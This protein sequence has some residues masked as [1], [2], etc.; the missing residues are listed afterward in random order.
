MIVIPFDP[1]LHLGPFALSWHGIFTAVGI[2]FGVALPVRLLRGRV[3]EDAA[4]SVATWG[5]IG[6]IVGARAVHVIDR[7]DF[8]AA[9]PIQILM[10]WNGGIAVLGAVLGGVLAGAF[11]VIRRRLPLGGAA[12]AAAPGIGLGLG[13]GRIGDIING[14]HHAV[15]CAEGPWCVGYSH[16]DTLGQPGPVHS[17]VAYEMAWDLFGVGI[18]LA[19]RRLLADGAPEGRIF[20]IWALHYAVG[21]VFIGFLRIG[22]PLSIFGLRQDQLIA[23]GLALA[24]LPMLALLFVRARR[25]PRAQ[26]A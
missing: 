26:G 12:D 7:W 5:V 13:I 9:D 18:A 22:D 21:R 14:E 10:I 6:G 15:A 3:S 1:N 2:L 25:Q 20:W 4:Y 24:A 16:P 8:Y 23:L 17:A 11:V 19:G